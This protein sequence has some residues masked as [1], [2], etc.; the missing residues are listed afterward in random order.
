MKKIELT[1]KHGKGKYAIVDDEDYTLL[2]KYKWHLNKGYPE[3][4]EYITGRVI[5]KRISREIM[6]PT[7][8][9]VVDHINGD[10]LDNRREN[11]RVC[12]QAENAKNKRG[13]KRNTSGYKGV[14]FDK[15]K[16]TWAAYISNKHIGYFE[17]EEIA[18]RAYDYHALKIH[19][20]FATLNFPNEVPQAPMKKILTSNFKGVS[21]SKRDKVWRSLIQKDGVRISLGSFKDELQ[22]AKAYNEKATELFGTTAVLNLVEEVEYAD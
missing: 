16:G 3:R 20:Q 11:L 10:K 17:N 9:L 5:H 14:S 13:N 21:W 12:T 6:T 7:G 1:G 19:K 18:A 15:R 8:N 4:S 2:S 22:A